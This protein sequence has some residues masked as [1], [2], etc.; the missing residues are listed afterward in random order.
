MIWF[1]DRY[2]MQYNILTY[3]N[4]AVAVKMSWNGV[5]LSTKG[6]VP[7][8]MGALE[9]DSAPAWRRQLRMEIYHG[10]DVVSFSYFYFRPNT[11]E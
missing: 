10:R 3:M 11:I 5:S 8:W 4:L 6:A 9:A 7:Q 1:I 2:I